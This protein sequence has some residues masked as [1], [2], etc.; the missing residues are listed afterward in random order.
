MGYNGQIDYVNRSLSSSGGGNNPTPDLEDSIGQEY[1]DG[2][3][4]DTLYAKDYYLVNN[5]L[6]TLIANKVGTTTAKD[7][8][9]ASRFYYPTDNEYAWGGR[10]ISS[11][12][13]LLG[14]NWNISCYNLSWNYWWPSSS[15]H[16]IRPIITLHPMIQGTGSGTS[17]DPYILS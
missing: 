2:F 1:S 14:Q 16:G 17:T 10:F 8:W 6:G 3:L 15:Q 5:A 9:L 11:E 12:G 4:G 13:K 7:Y